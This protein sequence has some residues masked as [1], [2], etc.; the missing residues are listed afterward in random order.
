MFLPVRNVT[1]R[2]LDRLGLADWDY[3]ASRWSLT[4]DGQTVFRIVE[5]RH[6][7]A[8]DRIEGLIR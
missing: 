3:S 1:W 2:A 5:R 8:L 4:D 6:H 7:A